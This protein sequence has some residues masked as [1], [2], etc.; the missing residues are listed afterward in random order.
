MQ[1]RSIPNNRNKT[2]TNLNATLSI[3]C[4]SREGELT[5]SSLEGVG[6]RLA[7]LNIFFFSVYQ[8]GGYAPPHP[9]FQSA[10]SAASGEA[11]NVI[12]D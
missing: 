3:D 9:H 12:S 6:C 2:P 1:E 10:A 11:Q 5:Q 8:V 4:A 7:S